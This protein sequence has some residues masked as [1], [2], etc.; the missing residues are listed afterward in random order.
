MKPSMA[1]YRLC[2]QTKQIPEWTKKSDSEE[3]DLVQGHPCA[4]T[5]ASQNVFRGEN[6]EVITENKALAVS[7]NKAL[8]LS[9]NMA[10]FTFSLLE[11]SVPLKQYH[12]KT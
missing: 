7:S 1:Q 5:I 11:S 6:K 3:S 9:S 10:H 4:C 12:Y 2:K 8:L